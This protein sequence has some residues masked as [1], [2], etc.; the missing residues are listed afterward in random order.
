MNK[1]KL[2]ITIGELQVINQF[3]QVIPV[4]TEPLGKA[5]NIIVFK[6]SEK[7]RKRVIEKIHHQD[8][9]ITKIT[10]EYP[11]GYAL[12]EFLNE[13]NFDFKKFPYETNILMKITERIF[14]QL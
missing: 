6:V 4:K 13:I 1:I 3:L 9:D 2:T 5:L 12:H 10:L 11:E 8:R 7:I 14:Q